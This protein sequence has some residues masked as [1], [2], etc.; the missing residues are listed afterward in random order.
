MPRLKV[1]RLRKSIRHHPSGTI[2]YWHLQ[3]KELSVRHD[4]AGRNWVSNPTEEGFRFGASQW[5]AAI[6]GTVYIS[7]TGPDAHVSFH[8]LREGPTV[9]LV[10]ENYLSQGDYC[11]AT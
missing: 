5:M 10:D 3:A 8:I 6:T 9:I 2:S 1:T 11:L 7:M 4:E